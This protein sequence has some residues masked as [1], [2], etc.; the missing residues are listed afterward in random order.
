[1]P[2]Y[3][4]MLCFICSWLF[5]LNFCCVLW[6]FVKNDEI[7]L[8]NQPMIQNIFKYSRY[9][10]WYC[11]Y[12]EKAVDELI[13]I[14]LISKMVN[15]SEFNENMQNSTNSCCFKAPSHYLSQCWFITKESM[16]KSSLYK[17]IRQQIYFLNYYHICHISTRQRE[18]S[19]WNTILFSTI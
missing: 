6:Y 9:N 1:M 11:S 2:I 12:T 14:H 8:Y 15:L 7:K 19:I 3:V 10:Y 16:Y 5:L 4:S 18:T 17:L 13:K